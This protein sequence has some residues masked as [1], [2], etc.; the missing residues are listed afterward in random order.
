MPAAWLAA[1]IFA[2]HPVQVESVAWATERKNVLSLVFYLLSFHAYLNFRDRFKPGDYLLALAFFIAALLSK[3]VTCSLPAAILLIVYWQTGRVRWADV[4]PLVPFFLLGAVMA[5]VTAILE[6]QH[7]GASGPEWN[8]TFADRCLIAGRAHVVL[9][10][11][12]ALA[13]SADLHLSALES[14]GLSPAAMADP[15][16]A[17]GAGRDRG[18]V[19]CAAGSAADRWLPS[20]SSPEPCCR[21]WGSSI[22]IRCDIRLSRIIFSTTPASA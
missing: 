7:V 19:A 15:V 11:E 16:P 2:V 17:G 9:R 8:F 22:C 3:S 10:G 6:K 20:C 18:A 4:R 21:R 14:D 5:A 12:T 1:A 13:A